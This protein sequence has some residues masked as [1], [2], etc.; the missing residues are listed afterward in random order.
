M[1]S[2]FANLTEQE[3][4]ALREHTAH[5]LS[6]NPQYNPLS[7]HNFWE[8]I[9]EADLIRLDQAHALLNAGDHTAAVAAMNSISYDYWFY[10]VATLSATE[11]CEQLAQAEFD[12]KTG[13][14]QD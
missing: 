8:A 2:V 6:T 14:N 7:S 12:K 1:K 13:M 10:Y 3:D 11:I 9:S 5:V 4:K